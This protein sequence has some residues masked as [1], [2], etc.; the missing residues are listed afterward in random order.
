[1]WQGNTFLEAGVVQC[2]PGPQILDELLLIADLAL[3]DQQA[4][5]LAED[6]LLAG[7]L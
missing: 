1:M 3:R 6:L 2:F 7:G 5:H 4:S